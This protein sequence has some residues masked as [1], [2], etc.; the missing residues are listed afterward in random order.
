MT[1]L[2][3]IC[4]ITI[5]VAVVS[6]CHGDPGRGF[7]KAIL[8]HELV[9]SE[10]NFYFEIDDGAECGAYK[11]LRPYVHN[12]KVW[13]KAFSDTQYFLLLSNAVGH[14]NLDEAKSE[15]YPI[16]ED[17]FISLSEKFSTERKSRN[18]KKS[19]IVI[20]GIRVD[21]IKGISPLPISDYDHKSVYAIPSLS[22][23]GGR[24]E[25]STLIKTECRALSSEANWLINHY[26][27]SCQFGTSWSRFDDD[28]G[29]S[30]LRALW[31]DVYID[32]YGIRPDF[33]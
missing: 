14:Q 33:E 6:G 19:L 16:A 23:K 9:G 13:G 10:Y 27:R 8:N 22:K 3:S 11:C 20:P 21:K 28:Y 4:F 26:P 18:Q 7:K 24:A 25:L 1:Y 2:K 29:M 17:E 31:T 32:D 5:L 12:Y 30:R 15:F